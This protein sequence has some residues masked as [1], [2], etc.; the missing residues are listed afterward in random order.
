MST[1]LLAV[2]D[3]AARIAAE[4]VIIVTLPAAERY[5]IAWGACAVA[6]V[7]HWRDHGTTP[8]ASAIVKAG[9]T[10]IGADQWQWA[11]DRGIG[12]ERGHAV[13]WDRHR[14]TTPGPPTVVDPLA[15][16]QVLSRLD[17]AHREVIE[18]VAAVESV[19]EAAT[20]RREAYAT[21]ARKF[22]AAREAFYAAWF[23][24]LTP[25]A[26]PQARRRHTRGAHCLRGHERTPDN[27]YRDGTCRRCAIDRAAARRAAA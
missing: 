19:D 3:K 17:V 22:R 13:Y 8:H 12:V 1:E 10:A 6:A 24:D 27:L 11:H 21:T 5:E 25:P 18:Q 7:E 23:D 16:V 26:L 15:V 4:G 2:I 9:L 14:D 20:L